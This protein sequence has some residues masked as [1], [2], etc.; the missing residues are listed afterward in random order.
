MQDYKSVNG[1][2]SILDEVPH[3]HYRLPQNDDAVPQDIVVNA[4]ITML[5]VSIPTRSKYMWATLQ[6]TL[7]KEIRRLHCKCHIRF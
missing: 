6:L 4:T 2:F 7:S 5:A 1:T 3:N